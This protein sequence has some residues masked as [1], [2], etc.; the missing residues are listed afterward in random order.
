MWLGQAWMKGRGH[1]WLEGACVAG[2]MHARSMNRQ[3]QVK[4]LSKLYIFFQVLLFLLKYVDN[5]NE[6]YF[7]F[8]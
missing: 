1:V 8:L 2:A 4:P 7:V 5:A 3:T 6:D